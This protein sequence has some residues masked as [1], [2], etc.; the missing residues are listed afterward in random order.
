MG[1]KE[2]GQRKK[3]PSKVRILL[4]AEMIIPFSFWLFPF[5]L[6]WGRVLSNA[7]IWGKRKKVKGRRNLQWSAFF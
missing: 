7:E 1:E 2:K 5:R 6:Q 4:N 3:E